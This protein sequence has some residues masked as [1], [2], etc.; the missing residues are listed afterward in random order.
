MI[1][2]KYLSL[3]ILFLL[4]GC[5]RNFTQIDTTNP[6]EKQKL[7][8]YQS[9]FE[10]IESLEILELA[11]EEEYPYID[12]IIET[13]AGRDYIS[14]LKTK[15]A[16]GNNPDIF[17]LVNKNDFV[18][19]EH[20]LLNLSDEQ[21]AQTLEVPIEMSSNLD[22]TIYGLPYNIEGYGILYNE[23]MF[24][25]I[26]IEE[27]PST[28]EE[29]NDVCKELQK[30]EIT[31]FFNVYTDENNVAL[32]SFKAMF[33]ENEY[34]DFENN[35]NTITWLEYIKM[36]YEY[37]QSGAFNDDYSKQ[38]HAFANN[39]VAMIQYGNWIGPMIEEFNKDINFNMMS[40]PLNE[41][42]M[43]HIPNYWCI[44][45]E[46]DAIEEAR[47]FLNWIMT[48]EE[49]KKILVEELDFVPVNSNQK[50]F[51][52]E[53]SDVS[54]FVYDRYVNDDY[55]INYTMSS[56]FIDTMNSN[57]ET[58]LKGEISDEEFISILDEVLNN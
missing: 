1:K 47:L 8:I 13:N 32:E 23:D 25:R 19:W 46:S 26:G 6:T 48:S 21:W 37:G 20:Y 31:P 51:R 2:I 39:E 44:Y 22:G 34:V 58:Y 14:L 9:K 43:V 45:N 18:E 10:V 3:I 27:L 55:L 52:G 5:T 24:E 54:Y 28:L 40:I 4:V 16:A 53:M 41:E 29:L 38:I 36:Q 35:P 7:Y 12:V 57:I 17:N 15:F 11:F 49:G 42:M 33:Y 56:T 30:K 50:I